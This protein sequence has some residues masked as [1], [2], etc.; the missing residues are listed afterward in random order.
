MMTP[1][2]FVSMCS[3]QISEVCVN[4]LAFRE[5]PSLSGIKGMTDEESL[6]TRSEPI[7]FQL[8]YNP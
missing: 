1:S 7:L 8:S 4:F 5:Q 2:Q 3:T 6:T